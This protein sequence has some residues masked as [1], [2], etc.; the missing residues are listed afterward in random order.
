M[1]K[2]YNNPLTLDELVQEA[3][4]RNEALYKQHARSLCSTADVTPHE[5][6]IVPYFAK[7]CRGTNLEATVHWLK[8]YMLEKDLI[9][10]EFDFKECA[11]AYQ[12]DL[13]DRIPPDHW[14]NGQ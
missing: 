8:T 12:S 13:H 11:A 14:G 3:K 10:S 6:G 5:D 7:E 1:K 9:F 4:K 2:I